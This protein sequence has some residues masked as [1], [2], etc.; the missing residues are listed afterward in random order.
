M[1]QISV[2]ELKANAG[3]YVSL[4]GSQDIFITKNG[5]LVARLTTAKGDKV[6]AARSLFG[7]LSSD[8]SIEQARE[9]RLR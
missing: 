1:M 4:V 7:I 3:K 8:A 9:E 2:S 5:K 6:A